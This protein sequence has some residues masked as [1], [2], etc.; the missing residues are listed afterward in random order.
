MNNKLDSIPFKIYHLPHGSFLGIP[1]PYKGHEDYFFWVGPF[2]KEIAEWLLDATLL[3]QEKARLKT[4][5]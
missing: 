4:T 2:H 5:N 1:V 3:K